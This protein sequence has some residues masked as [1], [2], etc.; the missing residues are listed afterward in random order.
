M[1]SKD[2]NSS[3]T[4]IEIKSENENV[5]IYFEF[6]TAS[7]VDTWYYWQKKQK[8]TNIKKNTFREYV[9]YQGVGGP[10]SRKK[11]RLS[12]KM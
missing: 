8:V 4:K 12:D 5:Y 6:F 9:P 1:F 10:P 2:L 3:D 11:I 7:F